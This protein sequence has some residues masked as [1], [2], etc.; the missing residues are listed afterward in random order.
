MRYSFESCSW[1]QRERHAIEQV[2]VSGCPLMGK[3]VAEFERVFA[4]KFGVK[5]AVMVNTDAAALL[6]SVAALCYTKRKALRPGDEVIVPAVID[7]PAVFA[8][9]QCG[10]R[11]KF[12]DVDPQTLAIDV[13]KVASAIT[14]ATKAILAVNPLGGSADFDGIIGLC[15]QHQLL[16]IEDNSQSLGATYKGKYCGTFGRCSAFSLSEGNHL[17]TGEGGVVVTNDEELYHIL[18]ALRSYGSSEYLPKP[19][20]IDAKKSEGFLLPGYNVRP[21]EIMGAVGLI[22]LEK[23]SSLLTL[24]RNNARVFQEIFKDCADLTT[25]SPLGDSSWL[26]FGLVLREA[27]AGAREALAEDLARQGIETR[28]LMSGNIT[29]HPVMSHL[30]H[31][32]H[33]TLPQAK[34]IEKQGF[35]IANSPVD[36]SDNIAYL[37]KCL[38]SALSRTLATAQSG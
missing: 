22:Q 1:D 4:A 20:K 28:P 8:L 37:K 16:L 33:G 3:Q 21:T 14:P 29:A 34:K 38:E 19:N 25:Q 30:N 7:A 26:G 12:V 2:L 11:A 6:L 27:T 35:L 5:Y 18:L 31:A 23:L 36:L 15:D 10:L 9:H 24:R 32:I 17:S 13:T